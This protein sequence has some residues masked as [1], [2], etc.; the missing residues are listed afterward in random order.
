VGE[1]VSHEAG[2]TLGLY[3]QSHYDESCNKISDYHYGQGS[4]EI[5]WAPIMGAGY[6]QNLTL[7]NNG[8]NSLG[9]TSMQN[10]LQII[11]TNNGFTYRTDDHGNIFSAATLVSFSGNQF[12]A[13]G[14]VEKNTDQ[15]LFKFILPAPGRFQ[16]GAVPY[17]VGTGNAGSDIDIQLTLYNSAQVALNVYN[18]G[19]LLN[20]VIDSTMNAG[21]YYLRIEGKGNQYAPNYASLGS[22]S[23]QGTFTGN[24][25]LPLHRLVLTGA[26][27]NNKHQLNW[28]ILSDEPVTVLELEVS[29]DG[30]HF[31]S[32]GQPIS[33]DRSFIYQPNSNNALQY[34][35]RVKL[36]NGREYY[37]NLVTLKNTK[38][39]SQPKLLSNF[40]SNN[41]LTITSPARY[42][43]AV[44]GTG[45][46]LYAKGQL[47]SG[48]NTVL[49]P[50]LKTGVYFIRYSNPEH[51]WTE[52][53]VRQ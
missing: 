24:I 31:S 35:L 10:D 3:H 38:G 1:G 8:P 28:E 9:C 39:Q 40:I 21:T 12:N 23:V 19:A 14:V 46:S 29:S 15:D 48:M 7:W 17:N 5:G 20:S 33:S 16:L 49:I 37:S 47:K 51:E 53:F 45:G 34:R 52:K 13:S 50:S 32:L 43:Y 44:Y 26:L 25:V 27:N 36:N 2:H 4:G 42:E 18:P 22:Y 6:Y 30:M 41:D 11:T